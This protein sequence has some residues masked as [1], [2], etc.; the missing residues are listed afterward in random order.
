MNLERIAIEQGERV[1]GNLEKREQ[2]AYE[3][4]GYSELDFGHNWIGF[5]FDA[6]WDEI[7]SLM[8]QIV[9]SSQS[10][11]AYNAIEAV[12]DIL[13]NETGDIYEGLRC[14]AE[15]EDYGGYDETY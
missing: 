2:K 13:E 7:Q 6:N 10:E 3:K 14:M 9:F 12:I 1:F 8:D 4:A 5:R 15:T 11:T